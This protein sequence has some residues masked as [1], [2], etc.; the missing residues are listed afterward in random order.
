MRKHALLSPSSAERWIACP[1]SVR[2]CQHIEDSSSAYADEGTLAHDLSELLINRLLFRIHLQAYKDRL[3]EIK[4]SNYYNNSMRDYCEAFASFVILE[5]HRVKKKHFNAQIFIEIKVTIDPYAKESFG[6]LDIVIIADGY[7]KF[8]DL[9]YGQGVL[10]EAEENDQLRMYAIGVMVT[11]A[12]IFE[13]AD[14]DMCIYQPRLNSISTWYQNREDILYW[15]KDT[16]HPASVLAWEGK[17]ELKAGDHCTF[18]KLRGTCKTN[19]SYHLQIAGYAQTSP[20]TLTLKDIAEILPRIRPLISWAEGVKQF[21][22]AQA[23]LGKK[24]PDHKIVLSKGDRYITDDKEAE[25]ILTAAGYSDI[26]I[27]KLATITALEERLGKKDFGH[28]LNHLIKKS[29]GKPTLVPI[30]DKRKEFSKNTEAVEI[31][32]KYIK[33]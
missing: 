3:K 21:A 4:E 7:C 12:D 5:Y 8:I 9:K 23:L 26:I 28:Y 14:F 22:L 18:C 15:A 20:H 6:F 11:F 17:G 1:P 32:S 24:I 29:K 19:A 30:N 10:V 31:F 16:M 13:F 2:L 25:K 33:T 27:R